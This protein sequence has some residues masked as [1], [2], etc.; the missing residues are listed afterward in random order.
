[1]IFRIFDRMSINR[2]GESFEFTIEYSDGEYG[3]FLG[4][5]DVCNFTNTEVR[6]TLDWVEEMGA[7]VSINDGILF[8]RTK[9]E[10]ELFVKC[11]NEKAIR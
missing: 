11:L 9:E 4:L 5:M 8:F 2:N 1:M 6:K 3:G 7:F 10:A